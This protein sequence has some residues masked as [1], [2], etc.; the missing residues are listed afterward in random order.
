M[1]TNPTY[2]SIQ[3]EFESVLLSHVPNEHKPLF[4]ASRYMLKNGGKRI[5]PLLVLITC[6]DLN[7]AKIDHAFDAAAAIEF[8]HNYSLIHDD[9]PCMDDDD[10]RRGKPTIHKVYGEAMAVLTGDFLLSHA[11]TALL[12]SQKLN[13][14]IKVKLGQNL[15]HYCGGGQLLEGQV[16]D[17][18]MEGKIGHF[19]DL[20]NIYLRKTSSLFCCALE[21][22]AILADKHRE[23]ERLLKEVGQK[24]GLAFQVR[25]DFQGK[26]KD[27]EGEKFTIFSLQTEQQ[28]KKLIEKNVNDALELLN[29]S[30][31]EFTK[32]KEMIKTF[33]L[34]EV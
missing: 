1:H 32:L 11:F 18:A 9:L 21:F 23:C 16:L 27:V 12:D 28:A 8:V 5:R 10:L 34:Y 26:Q 33:F 4:E 24:L 15:S 19:Y 22:G 6:Y 3:D 31:F 17:L 7:N 29:Q 20:M 30:P 25:N 2:K 13:N 14:D